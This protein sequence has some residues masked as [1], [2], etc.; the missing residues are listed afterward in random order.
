MEKSNVDV[1]CPHCKVVQGEN[2]INFLEGGNTCTI[3]CDTCRGTFVLSV[4]RIVTY[5]TYKLK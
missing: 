2:P 1:I 3:E 5:Y 4:E